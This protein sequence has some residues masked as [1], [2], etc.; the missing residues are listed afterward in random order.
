MIKIPNTGRYTT[1]WTHVA[2]PAPYTHNGQWR[3]HSAFQGLMTE[4]FE[5]FH[6]SRPAATSNIFQD[7]FF[8]FLFFFWPFKIYIKLKKNIF[9]PWRTQNI[10]WCLGTQACWD[11]MFLRSQDFFSL[12][13]LEPRIYFE[14]SGFSAISELQTFYNLK[15]LFSEFSRLRKYSKISGLGTF[16]GKSCSIFICG[17]NYYHETDYYFRCYS[18]TLLATLFCFVHMCIA[19][20]IAL[21]VTSLRYS[22]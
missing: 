13:I 2:A 17:W 5:A 11:R 8:F 22:F 19:E 21:T 20:Q 12:T 7:L 16:F 10:Y 6:N 18:C 9:Q 15:E 14:I 1:V 3:T 4:Y